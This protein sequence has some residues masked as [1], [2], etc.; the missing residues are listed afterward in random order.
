MA[1]LQHETRPASEFDQ[2]SLMP[3][4]QDAQKKHY[5]DKSS[6]NSHQTDCENVFMSYSDDTKDEETGVHFY[7]LSIMNESN[8]VFASISLLYC[9]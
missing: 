5:E 6:R 2:T 9:I 1:G 7:T 3:D 4:L 8:K